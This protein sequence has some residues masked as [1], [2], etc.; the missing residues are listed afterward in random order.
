MNT[1]RETFSKSE[2]LC[3]TKIIYRLFENG[4]TLHTALFKVVWDESPVTLPYPAQAAFSASKKGFPLAVTRNLIKRRMREA[5]RKKKYLLYECLAAENRQIVLI[6]IVK[7]N[8]V[9]GYTE[10]EESVKELIGRLVKII[11]APG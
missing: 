8:A 7:G 1:R 2:K 10:I 4:N 5:W 9:P 11:K 3:S 6:I